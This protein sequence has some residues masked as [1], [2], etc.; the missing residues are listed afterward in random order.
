M[1]ASEPVANR[2]SL[3]IKTMDDSTFTLDADGNGTVAA[4]KALIA[5]EAS[6]EVDLQRLIYRGKVLKNEDTLASY[7]IADG[8]TVHLVARCVGLWRPA[9]AYTAGS[10]IA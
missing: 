6:V 2:V 7:G 5:R 9:S 8:H 4:L 1:D 3:R 10:C